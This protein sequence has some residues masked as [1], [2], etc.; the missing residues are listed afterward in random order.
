MALTA[1]GLPAVSEEPV[2]DPPPVVA[3]G[4]DIEK[5]VEAALA[6]GRKKKTTVVKKP[7]DEAPLADKSDDRGFVL[8]ELTRRFADPKQKTQAKAFID[9]VSEANGGTRLSRLDSEL[10]PAIKAEMLEEFGIN[11]GGNGH[12]A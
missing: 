5:A 4:A 6:P 10:F 8:D 3:A 7:K 2:I 1:K 11:T 12:A 9:R